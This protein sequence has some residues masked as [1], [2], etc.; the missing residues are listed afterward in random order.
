VIENIWWG[1]V[2]ALAGAVAG[3]VYAALV[4]WR[5]LR[6]LW[7]LQITGHR[8]ARESTFAGGVVVRG[9]LGLGAFGLFAAIAA[10]AMTRPQAPFVW[11][12]GTAMTLGLV[13]FEL[14]MVALLAD[15]QHRWQRMRHQRPV[16]P[17]ELPKESGQ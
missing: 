14:L 7:L 11:N 12:L 6:L 17:S 5:G 16:P 8:G 9:A 13:L 4:L 15:D 3:I 10:Y 2:V 1:E